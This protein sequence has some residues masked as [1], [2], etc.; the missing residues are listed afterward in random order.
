MWV[1]Y[2]VIGVEHFA[3]QLRHG[4][5]SFH[6]GVRLAQVYCHPQGPLTVHQP[7]RHRQDTLLHV[8]RRGQA[9]ELLEGNH[10]ILGGKH[11]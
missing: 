9:T 3:Q 2:H 6:G 1:I 10:G 4:T 11:G 8:G 5:L 7:G